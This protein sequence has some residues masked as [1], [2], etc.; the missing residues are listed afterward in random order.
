MNKNKMEIIRL[1]RN[2]ANQFERF[3]EDY[4]LLNL[5]GLIS[6]LG[7]LCLFIIVV[8]NTYCV[9]GFFSFLFVFFV[10]R[11]ASFSGLSILECPFCIL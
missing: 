4:F 8:S 10:F 2:N 6:Y 5:R 1:K 9:V 11:V 7:Y 3:N